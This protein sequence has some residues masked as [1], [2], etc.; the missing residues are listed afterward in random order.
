MTNQSPTDPRKYPTVQGV[1]RRGGGKKGDV[2]GGVERRGGGL[3]GKEK[4]YLNYLYLISGGNR[5]CPREERYVLNSLIYNHFI[6]QYKITIFLTYP[7]K[8][9]IFTFS[10]NRL[11]RNFA[12]FLRNDFPIFL[13]TLCITLYIMFTIYNLI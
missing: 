6:S 4:G 3:K 10:L 5:I 2:G 13:E 8:C 1:E 7:K 11:M 9:E 12:K